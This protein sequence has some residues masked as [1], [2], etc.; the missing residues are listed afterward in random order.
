MALKGVAHVGSGATGFCHAHRRTVSWT[1]YFSVGTGGF[2]INGMDAVAVGDT[3]PTS[4]GHTFK[5]VGGSA[6]LTGGG[7]II[8][9]ED[10]PVIVIE[11]GDGHVI[12]GSTI[13]V[14]E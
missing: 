13:M 1:G 12:D 5:V 10:D 9:R 3:G 2:T 4:C 7:K 11:G 8:A 14:S 6:V